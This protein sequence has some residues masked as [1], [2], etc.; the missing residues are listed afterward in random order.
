M[1][2]TWLCGLPISK[3]ARTDTLGPSPALSPMLI[4]QSLQLL[5]LLTQLAGQPEV[6]I[7]RLNTNRL[8][9]MIKAVECYRSLHPF[10]HTA[11][12]YE[13]AGIVLNPI[14]E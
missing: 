13:E 14:P 10:Q 4:L 7:P 2:C 12:K 5:S 11:K 1:V 3:E 9:F 6:F 8:W